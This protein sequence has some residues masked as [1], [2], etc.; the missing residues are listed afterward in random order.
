MT[1]RRPDWPCSTGR[2][3]W[4]CRFVVAGP[5]FTYDFPG[6]PGSGLAL[7]QTNL[8]PLH[9]IFANFTRNGGIAATSASG[10]FESQGW[11]RSS[12]IDT[13]VFNSFTITSAIGFN[14][15]LSQLVFGTQRSATG[16]SNGRVGLF[17]N[18]SATA[19]ATFNFSSTTAM[20]NYT[21]DFADVTSGQN[22][23][24]ATFDFYGW[25]ATNSNGRLALDNVA[26][27][28]GVVA[29]P[30][31]DARFYCGAMTITAGLMARRRPGRLQ[32]STQIV[33]TSVS[34]GV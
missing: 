10:V 25:N 28:S 3:E 13:T 2:R 26:I 16:P 8:Q 23:Q 6:S 20:A 14:L 30:E 5:A 24:S 11:S 31:Q 17:L 33:G 9:L 15:T 4:P 27:Y 19:Y 22:V 21:F 1:T 29:V 12:S 32:T 7:G 18:G 34:D